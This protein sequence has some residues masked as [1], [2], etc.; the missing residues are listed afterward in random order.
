LRQFAAIVVITALGIA[1]VG[2]VLHETSLGIYAAHWLGL[3]VAVAAALA[4]G[5]AVL[6]RRSQRTPAELAAA[7][8][9]PLPLLVRAALPFAVYGFAYYGLL[10]T[11][12]LFAWSAGSHGRPF[13]FRADYEVGLDWALLAVTPALAYLEIA[14]HALSDRLAEE[15]ARHG[16]ERLDQHNR[17][18]RRFY[19]RRLLAIALL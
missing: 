14:V 1:V 4:W 13:T 18:Y 2:L 12:R 3:G 11:D 8:A 16:L 17:G 19:L 5:D 7:V 9:P 10:F 6:R 15:G